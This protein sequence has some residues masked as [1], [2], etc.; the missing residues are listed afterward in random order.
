M[1]VGRLESGVCPD[2]PIKMD[3]SIFRLPPSPD[4][5]GCGEMR[6][7]RPFRR[8]SGTEGVVARQV[9]TYASQGLSMDVP[10]L[11]RCKRLFGFL[12]YGSKLVFFTSVG[13]SFPQNTPDDRDLRLAY[14]SK[15]FLVR[16]KKSWV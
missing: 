16:V 8:H 4:Q 13:V 10:A 15:N 11:L 7:M 9:P 5:S 3:C 1:P 12:L 14:F 6:P 2:L